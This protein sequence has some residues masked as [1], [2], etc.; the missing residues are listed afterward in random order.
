MLQSTSM[1]PKL[2][3][4][5]NSPRR[6]Q[7][8]SL[9][10]WPF[11]VQAVEIDESPFP[12][13]LPGEYV[14]RLAESKARA[15]GSL[16]EPGDLILAADTTVADENRILGKPESAAMAWQMLQDLRGRAHMV[17]TAICV[18][19]R[20][21][22]RWLT[23]LCASRVW[24]R[25]YTDEDIRTYIAS[26]DP[27]DKAGGYAIQHSGFHPV[28]RIQGCY[29]CVVGLPLCRVVKTLARF[30]LT[31]PRDI[32]SG[33]P[34]A[35]ETDSACLAYETLLQQEASSSRPT[36]EETPD[37]SQNQGN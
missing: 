28:E 7:L 12:A 30:G 35:L 17:Y 3:L 13:E 33:C 4:A 32:T 2:F 22:D 16:V 21:S 37:R 29:N 10:G 15:A 1:A 6:R 14:S 31:P 27:F 23:D 24:M 20:Q 11:S 34:K 26:G 5:S 19:D 36:S 25:P 18:F 8:L 9:T